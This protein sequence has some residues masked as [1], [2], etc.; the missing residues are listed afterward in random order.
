[1]NVSIKISDSIYYVG[2]N[3]RDTKLF[4]GLWPLERGVSYNSYLILDEK[5]ALIDTVKEWKVTEFFDKIRHLLNGKPL[6]YLIIN[7]MEPDHSGAIPELLQE[8]P[9]LKIVG[10]RTTFQFIENLYKVKDNFHEIKDGESLNLGKHNLK[11]YLTPMVHWPETMVTYDETDKILFSGDAFGGFGTLDGGIFD[12]EVKIDFFEDEIRRYFSNIVGKFSPMVQRALNKLNEANIDIKIIAST[13]G[14]IW[15]KNPDRIYSLY[16]K[17]SKYE[18]EEG[19]VIAYGSMY[20]NTEEMADYVARK[21]AEEGIKKI[22]IMN[23]S[24]THISYIINEI[25]R[26]K[27]LILGSSTYNQGLFPYMESLVQWLAHTNIKNHVLGI[28]G[29]YGWSGGGVSTIVKYNEQ[30]KWP[31][32]A[33]PVEAR[34]SAKEEDFKKLSELAKAMAKEIKLA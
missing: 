29:T 7:H 16:D 4:E 15:R 14:P 34:L 9:N 23:V 28:F 20:G 5:T 26:Y 10:N 21:L 13:H 30:M 12:D 25:W 24:K 3:D 17:W 1:M 33:E 31:L 2:V 19:V 8:F 6:D 18:T 32:V 11:F 22:K 27:G